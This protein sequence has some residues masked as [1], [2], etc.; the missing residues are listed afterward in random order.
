MASFAVGGNGNWGFRHEMD[1]E[2]IR[3]WADFLRRYKEVRGDVTAAYPVVCG[4]Q[5]GSP[6]IHEK[7]N[8]ENGRGIVVFFTHGAGTFT[9]VTQPLKLVPAH[10][11]GA[12]SVKIQNNGRVRLTVELEED[13]ALVV[14]FH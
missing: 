6:E 4:T 14:F 1:E 11:T 5:G 8:T 12:Q 9:H 10:I 3:D 13:E 7:L 2:G